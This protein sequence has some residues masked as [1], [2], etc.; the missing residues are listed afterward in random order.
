MPS[1]TAAEYVVFGT[2]SDTPAP[3]SGVSLSGEVVPTAFNTD[4]VGLYFGSPAWPSTAV[5]PGSALLP[6]LSYGALNN[7]PAPA[8]GVAHTGTFVPTYFDY[9]Y[10]RIHLLPSGRIHLGVV[11]GTRTTDVTVWNA[12]TALGV[13]VTDLPLTGSSN[14]TKSGDPNLPHLMGPLTT[15]LFDLVTTGSSTD[16]SFS[17]TLTVVEGTA[18]GATLTL[19]GLA[20]LMLALKPE[21]PLD[22]SLMW[23]TDVMT[24]SNGK[25]QRQA[26]RSLP[27]E[28]Q[29]LR[30]A[31]LTVTDRNLLRNQMMSHH[32]KAFGVPVWMEEKPLD[33]DVTAG[34]TTLF[35]DTSNARFAVDEPVI[36]WASATDYQLSQIDTVLADRLTLIRPID[37]SFPAGTMVM[38]IATG[39]VLGTVNAKNISPQ[40]EHPEITLTHSDQLA[41]PAYT[42]PATYNGEPVFFTRPIANSGLRI[43]QQID[44]QEVDYGLGAKSRNPQWESA[45]DTREFRYL[46]RTQAELWNFRTFLFWLKGRYETFYMPTFQDDLVQNV[47]SSSSDTTMD[48][49]NSGYANLVYQNTARWRDLAILK[50][51]G[52]YY[53]RSI[54]GAT[55]QDAAT[56]RIQLDSALGVGY[57][58]GDLQISFLRRVRLVSD[59]V[60]VR[61]G[62]E[63]RT[64]VSLLLT[65]VDE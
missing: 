11:S 55:N 38:P 14:T 44:N 17:T 26:L 22:V 53:T 13:T 32:N 12:Y 7:A 33:L 52:T 27:R 42:P 3:V 37:A 23:A 61:H 15:I 45:K 57:D 31:P 5:P 62:R 2:L 28:S 29:R 43:S 19:A 64:S 30:Y 8:T 60:E 25:E 1:A 21:R 65:A 49:E 46:F 9:F 34:D 48:V 18:Q 50:P 51:D 16:F 41:M 59:R 24:S 54:I 4:K 6:Q 35:L 58:P 39:Q 47:T 10:N 36:V 63:D 40:F 56:D 20:S